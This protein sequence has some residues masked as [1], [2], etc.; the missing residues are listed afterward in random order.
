MLDKKCSNSRPA[1]SEKCEFT[2]VNDHFEGKRNAEFGLFLQALYNNRALSLLIGLP[3]ALLLIYALP[4]SFDKYN[5][6]V[7]GPIALGGYSLSRAIY[8]DINNDGISERIIAHF[9]EHSNAAGIL[10]QTNERILL[11]QVNLRGK[12][13]F[14]SNRIVTIPVKG[15]KYHQIAM[16]TS[17]QDSL[18]LNIVA[19]NDIQGSALPE[20]KVSTIFL[21]KIR[22]NR[23]GKYDFGIRLNVRDTDKDGTFE[24]F[25]NICAGYSIEPRK[26]YK[27]DFVTNK[28]YKSN[29]S[30]LCGGFDLSFGDINQDGIEE[31]AGG[32]HANW[33]IRDTLRYKYPDKNSYV[34]VFDST[35]NMFIDPL[36]NY[37]AYIK[38]GVKILGSTEKPYLATLNHSLSTGLKHQTLRLFTAKGEFV[39]SLKLPESSNSFNYNY[40]LNHNDSLIHLIDREGKQEIILSSDLQVLDKIEIPANIHTAKKFNLGETPVILASNFL[41]GE[42]AIKM[43]DHRYYR[44]EGVKPMKPKIIEVSVKLNGKNK[45]PQL[46]IFADKDEHYITV[47]KNPFYWLAIPYYMLIIAFSYGAVFLLL[48]IQ[49]KNLTKRFRE[50]ERL[51]DLELAS[52]YNQLDPH[53]TFNALNAIGASIMKGNKEE[54]YEYFANVSDLIRLTLESAKDSARSLKKELDFVR[55]YL[56]I[57][58]FRFENRFTYQIDEP[59]DMNFNIEI[60]KMLLQIFVE[61][62]LKHGISPQKKGGHISVSIKKQNKNILIEI[63]DNGI[64]RQAAKVI[65][66]QST[67]KG[68][69][70]MR[71]YVEIFNSQKGTQIRFTIEDVINNNIVTGTKVNIVV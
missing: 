44:I 68:L 32:C 42:Y 37:G 55:K 5:F 13:L 27:Y 45:A 51:R 3:I 47:Q 54:A 46:C 18:I 39:K 56:E 12:T 50:K 11:A 16:V 8:S 14:S 7:K 40:I 61:N 49:K 57:E 2:S 62:A 33:N 67:G 71:E 20:S 38:Y 59:E 15:T 31:V 24:L 64:G 1:K 6:E 60:P 34:M 21:D 52:A 17:I 53:F 25:V 41:D 65:G 30:G 4:L 58:E 10:V 9:N 19:L 26:L 28:L 29:T 43:P 63:E 22:K 69:S 70:V 36:V 23:Q 35:L 48:L 66:S